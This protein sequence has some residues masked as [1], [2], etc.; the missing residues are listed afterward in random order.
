MSIPEAPYGMVKDLHLEWMTLIGIHTLEQI[1][2]QLVS[3]DQ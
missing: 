2:E 3:F 1:N